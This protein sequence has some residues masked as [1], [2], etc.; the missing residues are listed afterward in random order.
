MGSF[1]WFPVPQESLLYPLLL[2][3]MYSYASLLIWMGHSLVSWRLMFQTAAQFPYQ[4]IMCSV[5]HWLMLSHAS[6]QRKEQAEHQGSMFSVKWTE[7]DIQNLFSDFYSSPSSLRDKCFS[8]I[9]TRKKFSN[10]KHWIS[11][12]L[13]NSVSNEN[14]SYHK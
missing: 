14:K 9:R 4:P 7:P 2:L 10:R 13:R 5:G 11:D 1:H 8:E 3:I 6:V 12:G